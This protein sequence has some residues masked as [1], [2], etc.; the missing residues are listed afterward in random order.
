M[1]QKKYEIDMC[2]GPLLGKILL[3]AIPLMLSSMLQL[4]FNAADVIVVG[5]FVGPQ[6][7]AAVGST[8]SLTNL[9]VNVF[10]GFSIGTNVVTARYLGTN[11][12]KGVREV[13]HTSLMF[14][15]LSGFALVFVGFFLSRPMLELMGTPED[16]LDQA[17]LYL[18]VY[19][20]ECRS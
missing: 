4:F 10:I 16:V 18:K 9:L 13:V 20:A 14:A 7:L 1:G 5:R 11:N 15:L 12:Q 6:A 2:N 8:S 17:A 19:L 3:F